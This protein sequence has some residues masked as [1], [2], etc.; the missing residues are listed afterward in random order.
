MT[1]STAT[2]SDQLTRAV[3]R[4][5]D[6]SS[7]ISGGSIRVLNVVCTGDET[8]WPRDIVIVARYLRYKCMFEV[9]FK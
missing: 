2:G 5:T 6:I 8:S 4:S 3:Y 7:M 1:S 9:L